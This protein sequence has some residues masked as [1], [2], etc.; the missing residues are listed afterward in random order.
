M[1][2]F[3]DMI[4]AGQLRVGD[5][6]RSGRITEITRKDDTVTIT[7]QHRYSSAPEDSYTTTFHVDFRLE[8]KQYAVY[9]DAEKLLAG[10][11]DGI[12]IAE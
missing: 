11:P 4:P 10:D 6:L 8:A 2:I 3:Y 5:D 1:G 12:R 7:R 9:L